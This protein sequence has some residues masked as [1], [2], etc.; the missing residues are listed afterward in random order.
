MNKEVISDFYCYFKKAVEEYEKLLQSGNYAD[1][2]WKK[3]N[4]LA[5]IRNYRR[6]LAKDAIN[7]WHEE[8][9]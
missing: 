9:D 3:A 1:Y 7:F 5:H 4:L 6:M 2:G 8:V